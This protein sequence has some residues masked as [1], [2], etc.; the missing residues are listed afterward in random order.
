[1]IFVFRFSVGRKA[2]FHDRLNSDGDV[3]NFSLGNHWKSETR[4]CE[5][6]HVP[7]DKSIAGN[8]ADDRT[9]VARVT[10]L[11]PDHKS[12]PVNVLKSVYPTGSEYLSMT[13]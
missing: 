6:L 11:W 1:L 9:S 7:K 8:R 13:F 4:R 10:C 12:R 5:N 2:D 3:I